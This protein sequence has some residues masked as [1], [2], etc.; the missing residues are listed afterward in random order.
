MTQPPDPAPNVRNRVDNSTVNGQV[1]QAGTVYGGVHYYTVN[2]PVPPPVAPVRPVLVHAVPTRQ[3]SRVWPFLGKWFVAL[4]PLL[5]CTAVVGG[6]ADAVA[7]GAHIGLRLLVDIVILALGGS[8]IVFWSG[9]TG[10]CVTELLRLVLDKATP[11]ALAALST[12][13][14][15]VLTGFASA[16]W[17]FGLVSELFAAPGDPRSRGANGALMFFAFLALLTGRL[18]AQRRSMTLPNRQTPRVDPTPPR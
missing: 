13:A 6:I 14:L 17:L 12:N 15:T 8:V 11:R 9:V 5:I 10:R 2:A 16:V 4:L 1:L 3:R 18:I 7:V